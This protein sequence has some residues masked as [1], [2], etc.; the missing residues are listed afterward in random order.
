MPERQHAG[1]QR[2]QPGS[3]S[4][5]QVGQVG[6]E[7]PRGP[8]DHREIAAVLGGRHQQ[9][10]PDGLRQLLDL[11]LVRRLDP[12]RRC[13]G[14]DAQGERAGLVE[15]RFGG[16]RRRKLQQGERIAGRFVQ[17]PVPHRRRQRRV[18]QQGARRRSVQ[19]V[20]AQL[21][22]AR[23]VEVVRIVPGGEQCHDRLR[24]QPAGGERQRPGGGLVDPLRV[25]HQ[26]QH[27]AVLGQVGQQSEHRQPDQERIVVAGPGQP[28]RA[29]DRQGLRWRQ[30]RDQLD[31]RTQQ[32]VQHRERQLELRFDAD[33]AQHPGARDSSVLGRGVLQESGL[34]DPGLPADHQHAAAAVARTG[35]Q[36]VHLSELGVAPVEH[37]VQPITGRV[38]SA[39]APAGRADDHCRA[40]GQVYTEPGAVADAAAGPLRC[41]ARSHVSTSHE[42][43]AE[44]RSE[45]AMEAR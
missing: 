14:T 24:V 12:A 6:P 27:R 18:R 42:R 5:V 44:S 39:G 7:R 20:Q 8:Q 38:P 15:V 21:R 1:V 30:S 36:A 29:T 40:G 11:P 43:V 41:H 19:S 3:F 35:E 33:R 17:D 31:R 4:R 13:A 16:D 32:Q 26:A 28:E 2:D 23:R 25:V 22:Q 34:P 10:R 37:G 45:T 9:Q